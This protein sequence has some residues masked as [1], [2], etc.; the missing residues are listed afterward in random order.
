MQP[1]TVQQMIQ[2]QALRIALALLPVCAQASEGWVAESTEQ[3]AQEEI[4]SARSIIVRSLQGIVIAPNEESLLEGEALTAVQGVHSTGTRQ[5]PALNKQ[6][7]AAAIGQP[8]NVSKIL[9]IKRIVAKYFEEYQTPFVSVTVPKQRISSGVLQLVVVPAKVGEVT[10]EGAKDSYKGEQ[11]KRYL[12]LQPGDE[13]N[14]H[15]LESDLRFIN[16]N[17]FRYANVIYAPGKEP[18]TTD[19]TLAVDERRLFRLYAGVNNTGLDRDQRQRA[20]V[21]FTAARILGIDNMLSY[22]YTTSY[23]L[24]AFR[25]NTAQYTSYL[26]WEHILSL[27][28]G[29]ST[30][31][32]KLSY[33]GSHNAGWSGQASAR[34]KVPTLIGH[35]LSMDYTVGFDYKAT[36]N[37]VEFSELFAVVAPKTVNLS[38]FVFEWEMTKDWD[39]AR[40]ECSTEFYWSPGAMLSNEEN[41]L[42]QMLRP[43]AINHYLYARGTIRYTQRIRDFSLLIWMRGQLSSAP[44]LPSEQF[45]LG[46]YDTVRGYD[47]RQLSM[48]D[49][50]VTNVEIRTPPISMISMIRKTKIKDALQFLVFCDYGWGKNKFF[51]P[52]EPSPLYLLGIGPGLRYTL[53]PY[54]T[55]RVDWGWKLKDESFYTGGESMVQFGLTMSY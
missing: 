38:Q 1:R 42:Y 16:Q 46:G 24:K 49:A 50:I 30:L 34:Y 23:D 13:I 25:G 37:S 41:S 22:Q 19:V 9:D 51:T 39:I 44:L 14:V 55:A 29:F 31:R 7:Q 2:N 18:G 17:P 11:L 5:Y 4:S 32:G 47:E 28:G 48:D 53:D 45:G 36:N 10:V 40:L 21:G 12:H 20:L 35:R 26:P 3:V 33:P 27:Y 52:G 6:L 43:G 8:L 54:L 15:R